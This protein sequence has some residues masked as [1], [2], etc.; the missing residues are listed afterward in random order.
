MSDIARRFPTNPL[1][2]PQDVRP[3]CEGLAVHC[4]LNPGVFRFRGKTWLLLRVAEA[5]PATDEHV[6]TVIRTPEGDLEVLKYR[7]DDPDLDLSDPRVFRYRGEVLLTTL[8]HLRLASSSDGVHFEPATSPTLEGFGLYET[9]GIEDCRVT[10]IEGRFYLTYTAV[11]PRGIAVG[12]TSTED[13]QEFTRHGNIFPPCN[14]DCALFPERVSGAY[15]ALHRPAS[16]GIGS[17]DIWIARSP[18]LIHW[19]R[20]ECLLRVRP[21]RWDSA[22]IGAGAS[23][24]RTTAGWLEIYHGADENY[25]YCLGAVLLDANDPTRVLARS[26]EPIMEP[27]APYEQKGFFG[28]V[29]FTNGHVVDGDTVTLYYG[30][31]DCVICGATLSI[32]E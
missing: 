28:N 16:T 22:R 25:R 18:D 27:I 32:R 26:E 30:A 1:L 4:L 3:S 13:W 9:W 23:P 8:S 5:P 31:S 10:E 29:V 21:G 15:W 11:S 14:K 6:S 7:R 17:H 19:G 12:M 20:H 2:S 24:I